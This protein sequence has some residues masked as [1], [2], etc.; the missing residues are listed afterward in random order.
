MVD[1]NYLLYDGECPLCSRY[2]RMMRLQECLSDFQ[3]RDARTAQD[4]VSEHRKAGREINDGMILA[5]N[6]AYYYGSEALTA[7]TRM[8]TPISAFNK[9][10]ARLFASPARAQ[11]LYPLMV[12][13]RKLLLIGLGRT[14]IG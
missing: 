6:G 12:M 5:V 13:G 8:T 10:S 9:F 14:G 3:L 4:L 2:V 7:I 11:S 1:E